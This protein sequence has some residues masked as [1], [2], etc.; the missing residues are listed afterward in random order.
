MTIHNT[1]KPNT[2]EPIAAMNSNRARMIGPTKY[3]TA[4]KIHSFKTLLII[5]F[6]SKIL[7]TKLTCDLKYSYLYIYLYQRLIPGIECL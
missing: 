4:T 1:I 5:L 7:I 6:L 2:N 3:I